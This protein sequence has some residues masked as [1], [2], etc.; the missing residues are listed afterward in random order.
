MRRTLLA[1]VTGYFLSLAL[2]GEMMRAFLKGL[3]P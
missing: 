1:F 2:H 3:F